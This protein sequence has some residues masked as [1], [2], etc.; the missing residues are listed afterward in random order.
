[1]T[2]ASLFVA[3]LSAL[4]LGMPGQQT[5]VVEQLVPEVIAVYPHDPNAYTQGLLLH[6]G[7]LY[8]STG[9]YGQSSVRQ[10]EP[11][12]GAV[13]RQ[14]DLPNYIFGEGLALVEHRLIQLT[15]REQI[16]I[17]YDFQSFTHDAIRTAGL[18]PYSGQG[19]GLCYD[20]ADI[21]MSDGSS[22]LF[23]RAADTFEVVETISVT[24]DGEPV[25]N[26]NELECVGDSI[27]ANVYLTDEIVRIDKAS[28]TVTAQ[29][30]AAGLLSSEETAQLGQTD[31]ILSVLVYDNANQQFIVDPVNEGGFV[32]NGIAYNAATDTFLITGKQWPSL[33]EVRFVPAVG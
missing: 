10:V 27:Y 29:I 4:L 15:W 28:G 17:T 31:T 26:L 2:F 9:R 25:Q 32:L 13:L 33:F 20:G 22:N 3:A 1:M 6:E 14:I 12:T 21:Y 18:I 11:E 30:H 24:R 23:R 5:T 19:W 16:A 8:E 7:L